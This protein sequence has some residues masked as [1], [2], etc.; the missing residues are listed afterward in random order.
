MPKYLLSNI[1]NADVLDPQK[2]YNTGAAKCPTGSEQVPES[3]CNASLA[4]R[5]L[6]GGDRWELHNQLGSTTA[7]ASGLPRVPSNIISEL[8][9]IIWKG[10]TPAARRDYEP[11][12]CWY[13]HHT[14]FTDMRLGLG[15]WANQKDGTGHSESHIATL[16]AWH[17]DECAEL[18]LRDHPDANGATWGN[19]NCSYAGASCEGECYAEYSQTGTTTDVKWDNMLFS[20]STTTA[21]Y[22]L[23]FN[24]KS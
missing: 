17:K 4:D 16:D 8:Q 24:P 1:S 19:T 11:P 18:V 22:D 2:S 15:H 7:L 13:F 12:G 21:Y 9:P 14:G 3:E 6:S 5:I 10:E 20:S 23:W